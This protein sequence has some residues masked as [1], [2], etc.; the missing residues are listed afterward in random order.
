MYRI[1][2]VFCITICLNML[3][4]AHAEKIAAADVTASAP[5]WVQK[6]EPVAPDA[7]Q[8]SAS[9]GYKTLLSSTQ[10]RHDGETSVWYSRNVTQP[11][12]I[13]G[14]ERSANFRW[15]YD[16]EYQDV[17]IHH[18]R[19]RRDGEI[20]DALTDAN[21]ERLQR[22]KRLARNV[23][24]GQKT[25]YVRLSDVRPGDVVDYAV[26]WYG[27]NP[28]FGGNFYKH[29]W[30]DRYRD[31]E[32]LHVKLSWD[33]AKPATARRGGAPIV[34]TREGN[35][36]AVSFGPAPRPRFKGET[37]APRGLYTHDR[38]EV[39]SFEDWAEVVEIAEPYFSQHQLDERARLEVEKIKAE[40]TGVE[41]RLNAAIRFVQDDIR[42]QAISLGTGGW[43]PR[44]PDEILTTR[45]GDC[46]DKS[47]LL[48]L[49]AE[50]LG[51][52][53]AYVALVHTSSGAGLPTQMPSM[54][55]FNH[56][57]TVIEHKGNRYWI[58]GT[59]R[60]QGGKFPEI[61][62]PDYHHALLLKP[63]TNGLTL[64][65]RVTQTKP[66]KITRTVLD[67]RSGSEQAAIMQI[68]N[69][70]HGTGANGMRIRFDSSGEAGLNDANLRAT[71]ASF[72]EAETLQPISISDDRTAN[73]LV[74]TSEY[75]LISPYDV[76][77][78]E[79]FRG[80]EIT[81]SALTGPS[82]VNRFATRK[83]TLPLAIPGRLHREEEVVFLLPKDT[84]LDL[85]DNTKADITIDNAAFTYKRT[86]QV[87]PGIL[88][89][90]HTLQTKTSSA[91]PELARDIFR[92]ARR[93]NTYTSV[94]VLV[95]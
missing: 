94:T 29:R 92:D 74:T 70:Y 78:D 50:A 16:P 42:Y 11:I 9:G 95:P 72:G 93:M 81:Y 68:E 54:S 17:K 76:P 80:G 1:L 87:G 85:L 71:E 52:E 24:T 60:L 51:A 13:K 90:R 63:G 53:D 62:Q 5:A 86:V 43:I 6:V 33:S 31:I 49:M 2:V 45:F 83:R 8:Y 67:L 3:P 56:A 35:M 14:V 38:L 88:T 21:I 28:A 41:A 34:P 4:H 59:M 15:N 89:Y 65:P 75:S 18:I 22:E 79:T 44:T 57:I 77:L 30:L 91:P 23:Y 69:V 20:I 84:N 19:I 25:I 82:P 46:K 58:D 10:V 26:S 37:G 32:R 40:H 48:A 73:R 47:V 39:S 7:S 64:M 12:T 55:V 27:E 66:S 61:A 36:H